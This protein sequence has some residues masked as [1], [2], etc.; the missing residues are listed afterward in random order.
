MFKT[1]PVYTVMN[2]IFRKSEPARDEGRGKKIACH[3]S[4][5]VRRY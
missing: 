5:V 2:N 4:F 3:S 1:F